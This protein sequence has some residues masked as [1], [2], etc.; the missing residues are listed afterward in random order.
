MK[1]TIQIHHSGH[2]HDAAEVAFLE[3]ERGHAGA[4]EIDYG[5]DYC[6][7]GANLDATDARAVSV[8]YPV[9]PNVRFSKKWPSFLLDLLPQGQARIH[10]ARTLGVDPD[11]VASDLKILLDGSCNPIGNLRVKEAHI[12]SRRRFSHIEPLGLTMDEILG[13]SS[14]FTGVV[15]LHAT[16]PGGSSA[17][18]GEWP[19]IAMT[20]ATDGLWYADSEVAEPDGVEHTIV[21]MVRRP[22]DLPILEAEHRYYDIARQF[23]IDVH[24]QHHFGDGVLVIPRFDRQG[25]VR[26]G[27]ESIV[28]ALGVS[29]FGHVES[30]ETYVAMLKAVSDDPVSDVAEYVLRDALNLATGN[31]DNHGRNTALRKSVGSIRLAPLFD[32]APMRLAPANVG[33]PTKWHCM[34]NRDFAP[35]WGRVIDTVMPDHADAL[36]TRL[37]T[38]HDAFLNIRD[39]ALGLGIKP[40]VVR[41]AFV[42]CETIAEGIG[43]LR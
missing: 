5:L 38:T 8:Q 26:F 21:K 22:D 32:F 18:Q 40:D 43:R 2:W 1:A 41:K 16:V 11:M 25:P 19:K 36:R 37:L 24:G 10:A 6:F 31:S 20:K 39:I 35:D 23:G 3:P 13:R 12:A 9:Q 7:G 42:D 27:Q 17:M 33:R 34:A 4:T 14:R 15:N 30:H 29:A 28:S